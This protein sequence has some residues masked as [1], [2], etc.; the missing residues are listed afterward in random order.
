MSEP[1]SCDVAVVG[2]GMVGATLACALA[3]DGWSVALIEASPL[4]WPPEPVDREAEP[5]VRVSAVS[6]ASERVFRNLGMWE[7][8]ARR[9]SPYSR[10][11]VWDAAGTGSIHFDSAELPWSHLGHIVEN[12]LIRSAALHALHRHHPD[13]V[14][15]LGGTGVAG[16][17]L[18]LADHVRVQLEDGGVLRAR[19]AVGADGAQSRLRELAG[20]RVWQRAYDQQAVVATVATEAPHGRCARQRFMRTGPL[21][22]LPLV[23]GRCSIVWTTTAEHAEELVALE[24]TAFADAISEASEYVLGRVELSGTRGAF[25]LQM[26]QAREYVA[27]RV[28]LVGDAAH[29][30]H[31]LA[32]QGA[33]LGILDVAALTAVLAAAGAP[34]ADPGSPR[35]LGRY[36]RWRKGH[37]LMVGGIMDGFKRAFGTDN[38][39]VAALRNNGLSLVDRSPA[40]KRSIMLRAMGMAGDLPPLARVS[41]TA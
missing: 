32:G 34:R 25:P 17:Q 6:V 35:L 36:A 27:Q 30:V 4:V 23:D 19:L 2:A 5:D 41:R 28:A 26:L 20:I 8:A 9:A 15:V 40:L 29:A 12:D 39:I 31:P 10:M 37:N 1:L 24:P 18:G 7:L 16:L 33:N 11:H 21:A 38:L 13:R 14:Q 22:M 3:A